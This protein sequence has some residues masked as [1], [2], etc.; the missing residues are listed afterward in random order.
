MKVLSKALLMMLLIISYTMAADAQETLLRELITKSVTLLQ[1][2][3]CSEAAKVAE[4]A[5]KVA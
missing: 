1:Q 3:E 2:G 4:K 5:L